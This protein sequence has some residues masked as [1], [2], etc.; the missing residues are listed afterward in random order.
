VLPVPDR[1]GAR[2]ATIRGMRNLVIVGAG[3]QLGMSIAR[4]FGAEGF[5]VGLVARRKDTLDEYV[6]ELANGGIEAVGAPADVMDLD[7]LVKAVRRLQTELGPVDVLEYSP[8]VNFANMRRVLDLDV[9]IVQEHFAFHVLGAVAVMREVLPAMLERGDGGLLFTTGGSAVNPMAS[10]GS[11]AIGV[12][13]LRNYA[14]MLHDA[15][16]PRGV[17]AGTLSIAAPVHGD[18]L[19]GVYWDM[20]TRR[21]R[22][23]HVEGDAEAMHAFEVL[24]LRGEADWRARAVT[25]E[26]AEPT[27]LD[28][29]RQLLLALSQAR[30]MLELVDDPAY[31]GR[32]EAM[33]LRFGGDPGALRCGADD[34]VG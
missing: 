23:E 29:R 5:R 32:L 4:R 9:D 8:L 27:T 11:A 24:T 19:A 20:Y 7:A 22:I 18:H 1:I 3:P 28:E 26:P 14:Y 2:I 6:E 21:D 17:Y 10:H 33:I 12:G 16:A 31:P 34:V 15:L 25:V 30:T 13:A